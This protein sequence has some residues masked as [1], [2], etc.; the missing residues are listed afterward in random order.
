MMTATARI[1]TREMP[2][3]SPLS[4]IGL[5]SKL[6]PGGL[7]FLMQGRTGY[8]RFRVEWHKKAPKEAQYEQ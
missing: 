5:I 4:V 1:L 8:C 2:T 3:P 7:E 6:G